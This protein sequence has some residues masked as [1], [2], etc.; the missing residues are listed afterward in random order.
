MMTT[1][2]RALFSALLLSHAATAAASFSWQPRELNT[3]PVDCTKCSHILGSSST[4]STVHKMYRDGKADKALLATT[5]VTNGAQCG[6]VCVDVDIVNKADGYLKWDKADKHFVKVNGAKLAQGDSNG[7]QKKYSEGGTFVGWHVC[8]T[9]PSGGK[10]PY[11]LEITTLGYDFVEKEV[12]PIKTIDHTDL[13]LECGPRTLTGSCPINQG[14]TTTVQEEEQECY[15][16]TPPTETCDA[17]YQCDE[18]N[19]RNY[20]TIHAKQ[21]NQPCSEKCVSEIDLDFFLIDTTYHECGPCPLLPV[22]EEECYPL[23]TPP[24]PICSVQMDQCD[25]YNGRVYFLIN[26]EDSEAG[27]CSTKCVSEID[28]DFMVGQDGWGCGDCD[29]AEEPTSEPAPEHSPEPAP[30]PAPVSTPEPVPAPTP[31]ITTKSFEKSGTDGQS[32]TDPA[33]YKYTMSYEYDADT[34]EYVYSYTV[35]DDNRNLQHALS[36]WNVHFG[37]YRSLITRVLIGSLNC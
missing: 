20:Y 30:V 12:K 29:P 6:Q 5:V 31:D 36:H 25:Y 14:T 19:G 16:L 1:A 37:A 22:K 7:F 17:L 27:T 28:I 35:D 3:D 10:V 9:I 15:P 24:E 4:A 34:A 32:C 21:D 11:E 33:G 13:C 26:K 2:K 23:T 8:V 18:Y